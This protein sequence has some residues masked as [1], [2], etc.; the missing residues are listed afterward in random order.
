VTYAHTG[1]GHTGPGHLRGDVLSKSLNWL[2]QSV[3]LSH[4]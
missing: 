1:V 2:V 3:A 4:S